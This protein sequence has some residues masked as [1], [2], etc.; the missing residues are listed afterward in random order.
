MHSADC[1]VPDRVTVSWLL[2]YSKDP[3]LERRR[4]S[5]SVLLLS[6]VTVNSPSVMTVSP[7]TKV[8]PESATR[9]NC[10]RRSVVSSVMLEWTEKCTTTLSVPGVSSVICGRAESV[11]E[12]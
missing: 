7:C 4:N 9:L 2:A 1:F 11:A 5:Y 12:M 6:P 8:W 3:T 10:R